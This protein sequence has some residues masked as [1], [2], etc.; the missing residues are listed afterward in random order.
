MKNEF[1]N[2]TLTVLQML[3]EG[4][5]PHEILSVVKVSSTRFNSIINTLITRGLI[6][7]LPPKP[8]YEVTKYGKSYLI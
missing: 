1:G 3:N 2:T 6:N 5:R 7:R 4:K 8:L